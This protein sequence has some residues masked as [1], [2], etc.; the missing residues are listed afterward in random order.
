MAT[1]APPKLGFIGFG[2]AASALSASL[3]EEGLTGIRAYDILMDD[4]EKRG[5][6]EARAEQAGVT[7][8]TSAEKLIE[9]CEI[10][11][12]AVTSAVALEVAQYAALYLGPGHLYVDINSVSPQTKRN[13]GTAVEET[14]AKFIEAAVMAAVPPRRHRVPILL[15]GEAV[16]DLIDRLSPYGMD[17]T[18]AGAEW[19]RASATKMCRSIMVKGMEAL[20]LECVMTADRY[21]VA[22]EVLKSVS[23]SYP[24]GNWGELA[25][26]FAGR[27]AIHGERRAHEMEEVAAMLESLD[28]EPIMAGAAARR[29]HWGGAQGLKDHFGGVAPKTYREVLEALTARA[30][31]A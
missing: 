2:E 15:C 5:P 8:D 7:L 21:G 12:S 13:V 27:T 4:A 25:D 26:Y 22:D 23:E 17:L 9:K 3:K 31:K 16:A 28:I 30:G 20:L 29:I 18:D 24:S 10:V 6:V 14:D 19:G 11:I 1:G